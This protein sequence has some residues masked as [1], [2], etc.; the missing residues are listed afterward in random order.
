MLN[1][2]I[3]INFLHKKKYILPHTQY[4]NFHEKLDFFNRLKI[5]YKNTYPSEKK[6]HSEIYQ[7]FYELLY[8]LHR[9]E[10][11]S[12]EKFAHYLCM[13][14]IIDVLIKKNCNNVSLM[15]LD[16]PLFQTD[17]LMKEFPGLLE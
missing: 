13:L 8:D 1:T 9:N 17:D 2:K 5:K 14:N 12:D 3:P 7:R 10:L 6:V 15:L 16:N 4:M 11:L